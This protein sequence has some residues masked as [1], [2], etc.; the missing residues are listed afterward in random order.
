MTWRFRASPYSEG[1][2]SDGT[3]RYSTVRKI[4]GTS[5]RVIA[6]PLSRICQPEPE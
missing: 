5:K 4:G 2:G 3:R 1:E 6:I